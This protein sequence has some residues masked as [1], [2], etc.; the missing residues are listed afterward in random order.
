MERY[1]YRRRG[2]PFANCGRTIAAAGP[3][4]GNIAAIAAGG[5]RCG[6]I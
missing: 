6:I 1:Y 4:G 2:P 3:D 5:Q